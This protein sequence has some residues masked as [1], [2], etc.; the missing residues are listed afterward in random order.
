VA[1]VEILSGDSLQNLNTEICD[2]NNGPSNVAF[3]KHQ[4]GREDAADRA[5][6]AEQFS[7]DGNFP[8][9]RT[10]AST[11]FLAMLSSKEKGGTNGL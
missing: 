10:I 9:T 11:A 4:R 2:R 5:G 7:E 3:Q 8:S 1:S 6:Y